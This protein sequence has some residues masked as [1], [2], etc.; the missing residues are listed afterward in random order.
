[1][2]N[3]HFFLFIRNLRHHFSTVLNKMYW[4]TTSYKYYGC[5]NLKNVSIGDG[6]TTIGNW[7][8]FGCSSLDYFSYGFAVE[9]IGEEAFSDCVNVT[10]LISHAV[11]PPSCGTQA[12]DDINKWNCTLQVPANCITQYQQADQWKEFFFVEGL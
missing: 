4:Y 12:L 5:A 9:T 10:K 3:L 11:T 6:V 1:M 7:A 2:L 8:F